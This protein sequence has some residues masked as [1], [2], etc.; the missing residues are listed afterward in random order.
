MKIITLFWIAFAGLALNLSA[1]DIT[2]KVVTV[3]DGNTIEVES[4]GNGIQRIVFFGIDC[5]ELEQ[6]YGVEAKRFLEKMLLK[7]NVKIQLKGKDRKGNHLAV[8][9]IGDDDARVPLLKE[10]L[11]W[12]DERSP[13]AE[14][15]PYSSFAQKKGRGLWKEENP[16][17]PW[18][19]RRQQSM[20]QPKSS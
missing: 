11:A 6:E 16:T 19:F 5:P 4:P 14:L 20:A 12:I 18:V 1:N 8:V 2:A 15:E 13:A 17:P 3:I 10:G 9:M 7:K